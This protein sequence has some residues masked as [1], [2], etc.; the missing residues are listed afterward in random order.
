MLGPWNDSLNIVK[1]HEIVGVY[2]V[3]RIGPEGHPGVHFKVKSKIYIINY[4]SSDFYENLT[5]LSP[6]NDSLNIVENH[7]I[8]G[9]HGVVHV[10]P[11]EHPGVDF[12]VNME[13]IYHK[14][15]TGK[16]WW[17]SDYSKARNKIS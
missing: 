13:N 10:G 11:D 1:S 6:W 8:V 9:A 14:L 17:N 2:G 4:L 15:L 7:E 5:M 12:K 16:I 3:V